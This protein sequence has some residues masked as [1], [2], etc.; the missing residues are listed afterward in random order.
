MTLRFGWP[1]AFVVTGAT[2]LLCIEVAKKNP[3]L[4]CISFDLPP[5]EPIAKKHIA[6]AGLS[7]RIG[8][9]SGDFFKDPLPKADVLVH[10]AIEWD[11]QR[12][13]REFASA[14]DALIDKTAGADPF[15]LLEDRADAWLCRLSAPAMFGVCI[16]PQNAGRRV[17][18]A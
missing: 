12:D 14:Y 16:H 4:K 9:A 17:I 1:A 5:V 13:T 7:D 15:D 2:G 3:H 10:I 8:T 11:S 18:L 6:A